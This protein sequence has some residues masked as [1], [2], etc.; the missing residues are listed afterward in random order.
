MYI[1]IYN[2]TNNMIYAAHPRPW[3]SNHS[4]HMNPYENGL[5]WIDD[6]PLI[7]CKITQVFT[8]AH[9]HIMGPAH[10]SSLDTMGTSWD[11]KRYIYIY[12]EMMTMMSHH[13]NR[14]IPFDFWPLLKHQ[15]AFH[16]TAEY[17]GSLV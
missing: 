7:S 14:T 16:L 3:E 1:C 17:A 13:Q 9:F 12:W 5:I 6:H 10:Y 15:G 8:V 11:V 4:G 2:I